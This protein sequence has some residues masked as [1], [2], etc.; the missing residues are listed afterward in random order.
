MA[1]SFLFCVLA[2]AQSGYKVIDVDAL[3]KSG[4]AKGISALENTV[5]PLLILYL[6]TLAGKKISDIEFKSGFLHKNPVEVSQ[7]TYDVPKYT[8]DIA[9]Y[10]SDKYFDKLL[11]DYYQKLP[12]KI[13]ADTMYVMYYDLEKYLLVLIKRKP[14][15]MVNVLK[16]DFLFW[17]KF[18]TPTAK[19][20]VK[21]KTPAADEEAV[22]DDGKVDA[23]ETL[24]DTK[25]VALQI[26]CALNRLKVPEFGDNFIKRF[27]L[28]LGGEHFQNYTFPQQIK[29]ANFNKPTE[30]IDFEL[31]KPIENLKVFVS[32]Q[33]AFMKLMG[34]FMES[35]PDQSL[36]EVLVKGNKV[37]FVV[38]LESSD[39]AY[40]L[41]YLGK[42]NL[43]V[44]KFVIVR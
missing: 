35:K 20:E 23:E 19:Q 24:N 6:D 14:S 31:E 41:T 18:C 37:F 5:D 16:K 17:S 43:K 2:Y 11:M 26:A 39:E 28:Q 44:E 7:Y 13:K 27:R 1:L 10:I 29:D 38:H 32:N 9:K 25:M 34:N 4:E 22:A 33:E 8:L 36:T 15:E 40:R 30:I 3:L 12:R 21:K 42:L